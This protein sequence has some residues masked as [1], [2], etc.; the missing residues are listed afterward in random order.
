LA[1][2]YDVSYGCIRETIWRLGGAG[3]MRPRGGRRRGSRS[4]PNV[5]SRA[6]ALLNQKIVT[7]YQADPATVTEMAARHKI[8]EKVV[9]Q[10]LDEAGVPR[11]KFVNQGREKRA[12]AGRG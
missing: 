8:S 10:A 3:A 5:G 4:A 7:S 9:M 2:Q 6:R 12:Q 11:V 1:G